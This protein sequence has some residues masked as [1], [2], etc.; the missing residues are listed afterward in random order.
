MVTNQ[1]NLA[2]KGIIAIQAMSKMASVVNRTDDVN[3]YA[4]CTG[5]LGIMSSHINSHVEC[6]WESV[7]SVEEPCIEQRQASPCCVWANGFVDFGLQSIRRCVA[8]H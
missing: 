2:I 8:R 7:R 1:T 3:K 5:S 6:C 4:V